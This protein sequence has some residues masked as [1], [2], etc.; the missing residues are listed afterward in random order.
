MTVHIVFRAVNIFRS[1]NPHE[2]NGYWIDVFI[3]GIDIYEVSTR[4]PDYVS[5][6]RD[7]QVFTCLTH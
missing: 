1:R 5:S 7:T 3:R 4:S 6:E 2:I